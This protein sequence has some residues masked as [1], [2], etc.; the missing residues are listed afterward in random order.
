MPLTLDALT[1]IRDENFAED[2][3]ID[4]TVMQNW[5]EDQA[6]NYFVSGGKDKPAADDDLVLDDDDLAPDAAATPQPG[7][8]VLDGDDDDEEPVFQQGGGDVSMVAKE[9]D[10]ETERA[11]LEAKSRGGAPTAAAPTGSDLPEGAGAP[12][13]DGRPVAKAVLVGDSGVGKTSLM[14]RFTQDLYSENT[15]ATIGVD[16]QTRTVEIA[17]RPAGSTL[18]LQLWD[19]AGQEQFASLTASFFRNAHAVILSYDVH[20]PGSFSALQKWMMEVD[21]HA[22]AEVVKAIVGLKADGNAAHTAVAEAEAAAFAAKHGALCARCSAR[23]GGDAV[24]QIF[25]ALAER[26]VKNGFDPDGTKR[27]GSQ[28]GVKL[29]GRASA[30]KAKKGGCC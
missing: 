24:T 22:P 28:G 7:D 11:D 14:R 2:V 21:R 15:K 6:H 20:S 4:L 5:T 1:A 30:A 19:T 10:K 27:R 3:P 16:L 9:A 18:N 26:L 12:A 29:G 8:L 25:R 13:S 17:G 23:D